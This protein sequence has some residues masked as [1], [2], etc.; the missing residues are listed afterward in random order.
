[1]LDQERGQGR[2][3]VVRSKHKLSGL[4]T[5]LVRS[6][7]SQSGEVPTMTGRREPMPRV[8]AAGLR[9]HQRVAFV[10]RQVCRQPTRQSL[11]KDLC[12]TRP[13]RVKESPG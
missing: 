4:V 13:G 11:L 2:V 9:T 1:M 5:P 8:T 3:A 7:A 10:V 6:V 12:L